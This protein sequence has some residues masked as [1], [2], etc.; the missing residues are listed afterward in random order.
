MEVDSFLIDLRQSED[1]SVNHFP[2]SHNLP[3][4]NADFANASPFFN[5]AVLE[6]QWKELEAILNLE[7][8]GSHDLFS[9]SVYVICYT[10]DTARVATSI[11]RAKGIAAWSVK[12]GFTVFQR[13]ISQQGS[14]TRGRNLDQRGSGIAESAMKDIR[15]D[16]LSPETGC[17]IEAP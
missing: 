1:F 2:G 15:S 16:S 14:A 6:S 7:Y 12:G 3:L 9:K 11:L 8:L 10:G 17:R 4:H 5:P 13:E